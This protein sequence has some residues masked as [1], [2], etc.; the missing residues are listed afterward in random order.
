M[1]ALRVA[2]ASLAALAVAAGGCAA[3][4][5]PPP[6]PAALRA[7][8]LNHFYNLEYDQAIADF[9]RLT[10]LEPDHA[11][12]W[13][14]LA[15][16][17]LYREM[18]RIGA[19]ESALYGHGDPFL[20]AKLLPPDPAAVAAVVQAEERALQLASAAEQRHPRD[21]QAYYDA[22]SAWALRS[23]LE[24]SVQHSYWSALEDAKQARGEA[25]TAETIDPSFI[26]PRLLLGVDN[27]IAG[28]LP[29]SVK[30]FSTLVG[31]RGNKDKG[32]AQ[33]AAVAA[34]GASNHIDAA[35]L[36]ALIDRRDGL[37][38][39]AAPIFERLAQ[40]FPR[41]PV[42]AVEAAEALEAA[43]EHQASRAAYQQVL[44]RAA[45]H[46]PGYQRAP[47]DK[48]WYDLGKIEDVYSHWQ[49]A[50]ADFDRV[51][52]LPR[53]QPRYRQAAALA[54]GLAD[55]KAGL[56]TAARAEFQ[57]CLKIDSTTPA[58]SAAR[59]AL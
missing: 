17:E 21:A 11:G 35:V 36:L 56:A 59:T 34:S 18:Y 37:N 5:G 22:A 49:L 38:Q 57:A 53:A 16:A 30:I 43:G 39:Q 20:D 19:L 51:Q 46:A 3:Q 2:L 40:Q 6:S 1:Q 4:A 9:Q 54:A 45:A 33:I 12:P 27:Y 8:G 31:Y 48:V 24:F 42:M 23:N 50:A 44:A 29:W 41:N 32:R 10:Q 13:N 47:L 25:E 52:A 28:S 7:D 14:H 26:E 58:A 15:Q 55:Q